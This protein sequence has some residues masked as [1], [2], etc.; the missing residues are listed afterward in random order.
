MSI[1]QIIID[2]SILDDSQYVYFPDFLL[3]TRICS[4]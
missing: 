1:Y 2:E 3:R 4:L